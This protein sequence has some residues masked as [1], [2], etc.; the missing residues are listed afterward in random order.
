MRND[1]HRLP[2]YRA[3]MQLSI[4]EHPLLDAV[5]LHTLWPLPLG[6]IETLDTLEIWFSEDAESPL[7]RN[8][9]IKT[10]VRDLLRH[11]GFKPSG[12]SKPASEYLIAAVAKGVMSSINPAVDCCNVA[13]LHS[14]LPISVVDTQRGAGPWRIGLAESNTQYVFN[15]T[16]QVIDIGGLVVLYDAN[17]PCGGPV[18]DSQ[19]TKTHPKTTETLSVV[20]GTHQLQGRSRET[21]DWYTSLMEGLGATVKEVTPRARA[22]PHG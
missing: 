17:G 15:P 21:A 10:T 1:G 2:R 12:R 14:G 18:K 9:A 19:R 6:E 13:S 7:A 5:L 16:G 22:N 11:G 3:A 4:D 20:W 8:D